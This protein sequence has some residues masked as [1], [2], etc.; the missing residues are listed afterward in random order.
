M[1]DVEVTCAGCGTTILKPSAEVR[2]QRKR[3]PDREFFCSMHCYAVH[4]GHVNL[5]THL[6]RGNVSILRAGNRQDEFSPFR[7]F[8]LEARCR[9]V[10]TNLDLRYLQHLW[11]EQ[12]GRCQ[13]S[14]LRLALPRNSLEWER[15]THDP[16]K[17]SLDRIDSS[18]GY[19]KGNVRFVAV[20]ANLARHRFSDEE[21]VTFCR[22]VVAMAGGRHPP[23][24]DPP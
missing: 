5:G 19:F 1:R 24:S 7:Y 22:A 10:G 12:G 9:N 13:V 20:I 18:R 4:R 11:A 16:W 14:G 3:N 23:A 15:R 8:L 6:G 2:R 21:L 17:P